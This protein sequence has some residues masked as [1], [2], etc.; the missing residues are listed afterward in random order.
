[1]LT[2]IQHGQCPTGLFTGGLPWFAHCDDR[3]FPSLPCLM[4]LE[5]SQRTLDGTTCCPWS[6][7]VLEKLPWW[8]SRLRLTIRMWK[9]ERSPL[10]RTSKRQAC[11]NSEIPRFLHFV[12]Y[13]YICIYIYTHTQHTV[14]TDG[15]R[16]TL[17]IYVYYTHS[18]TMCIYILYIY[19]HNVNARTFWFWSS[20]KDP[21]ASRL[22][23]WMIRGGLFLLG[24][25]SIWWGSIVSS[26]IRFVWNWSTP[27][28]TDCII[29]LPVI[30][31]IFFGHSPI[32]DNHPT[33]S[34]YNRVPHERELL[35]SRTWE[36]C[37]LTSTH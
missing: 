22:T 31:G 37:L 1:M 7:T 10:E 34:S 5:D 9:K 26:S 30:I 32:L 29:I 12:Y 35:Q 4:T 8:Q 20:N 3:G 2:N 17:T 19:I 36:A 21:V 23:F 18:H 11:V 27:I 14:Y 28:P 6:G 33:R 16:N 24:T 15:Y 13:I 25:L